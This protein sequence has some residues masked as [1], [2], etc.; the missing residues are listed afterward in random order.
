MTL[1]YAPRKACYIQSH[2]FLLDRAYDQNIAQDKSQGRD[3][4]RQWASKESPLQ[5]RLCHQEVVAT[6]ACEL[7]TTTVG[8]RKLT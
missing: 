7:Q 6:M 4:I 3:V 8:K 2:P 5:V 1:S